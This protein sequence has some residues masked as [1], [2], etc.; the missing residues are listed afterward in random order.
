MNN[1]TMVNFAIADS[2]GF[3]EEAKD[4]LE[5]AGQAAEKSDLNIFIRIG[6]VAFIIL[7]QVFLIWLM[8]HIAKIISE[9]ITKYGEEKFKPLKI[10]NIT[11]LDKPQMIQVFIFFINALKIVLS[12][13]QLVFTIP[14]V[15]KFFEPTR[16]FADTLFSYILTPVKSVAWGFVTYIPNLFWIAI[17][18]LLARYALRGLK[19]FTTQIERKKLVIRGFYPDWAQPTFNI[20]RVFIIAFTVAILYPHL[21]NSDSDVF[22]GV[23]V[24]VG[25]IFSLGSSSVVGNLVSG[26]VMT[27]MRPFQ[28]GDRIKINDITGFV[29]ER[30]PMV[31]RIRTHKN[32]IISLPNQMVMNNS[33]TNYSS[34]SSLGYPGLIIHAEVT[35]GYDTPWQ[36]VHEVLLN[37][38]KKT[39]HVEP[40]PEPFINQIALDDFY[41]HYEVNAFV[42]NVEPLPG[43]YADLYKN[44]QIGFTEKGLS[45]YAPH[46]QVQKHTENI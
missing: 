1:D 17:I 45:L 29:L 26:L 14:L 33:I 7:F 38:A 34:A 10:K 23:S 22:K 13:I 24:L 39:I 18:L 41:C 25:V 11:L 3:V 42:K 2:G 44:I 32:E 27:Y 31:T 43:I 40:L 37:A 4:A 12:V 5:N 6:I 8:F 16:H 36:T 20:L 19:F 46:Y 9:K 35:F 15:F 21:P 30:G 28:T